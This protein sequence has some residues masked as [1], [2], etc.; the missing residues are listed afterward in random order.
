MG[1][2]GFWALG[3]R[4]NGGMTTRAPTTRGHPPL[5]MWMLPEVY[6]AMLKGLRDSGSRL[7]R[8][9]GC[10]ICRLHVLRPTDGGL[11]TPV[12]VLALLATSFQ[13]PLPSFSKFSIAAVGRQSRVGFA[14]AI[15]H[16]LVPS[17]NDSDS[18]ATAWATA[19]ATGIYIPGAVPSQKRCAWPERQTSAILDDGFWILRSRDLTAPHA[20]LQRASAAGLRSQV[21]GQFCACQNPNGKR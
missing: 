5:E 14:S 21:S 2:A 18:W 16:N 8:T 15:L 1:F 9:P 13:G 6:A 4:S 20:P 12:D 17:D 7:Q 10:P 19:W 3:C 11:P